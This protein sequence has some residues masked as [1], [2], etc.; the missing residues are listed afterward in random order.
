MKLSDYCCLTAMMSVMACTMGPVVHAQDG[1]ARYGHYL[2]PREIN[3]VLKT[4]NQKYPGTTRLINLATTP[5]GTPLLLIEIS[6]EAGKPKTT[7]AILVAANMEGT[8]PLSSMGALVLANLVLEKKEAYD[9]LAWYIIPCGNPDA[10]F[11]Y[12][13]KPLCMDPRNGTPFNE[14]LDD[15]TDEDGFNDL[16]GNGIITQMRVKD[17]QGEWMITE[18]DPQMMKRA[19]PFKGEKGVYKLYTEG[20]DDDRDGQ[21]N[22]DPP[23]GT[24]VGINFPHLFKHENETGGLW[25]GS[26]PE[27]FGIMKYV[28]E[29]PEIAMAF[30]F[31]STDFCRVSPRGGRRGSVNLNEI[32]IPERFARVFNADPEKTYTMAE[33]MDLIKPMMPEG[34]EVTESM[35]AGFLGLGAVINPLEEDLKF[36]NELSEKYKEYL[37]SKNFDAK[38]L[39]AEPDKDGSI[40]LWAYYHLGIPSFSMN[41]FTLPEP[42]EE[43]KESSGITVEILEKMSTEEFIAL[44]PGKVT[45]FMKEVG[46]PPQ[47]KAEQVIEMVKSGQ[48]PLAQIASM[49]KQMPK[50]PAAGKDVDPKTK[51]LRV[52]SNQ[53]LGGKGF[54]EWKP[55][56]HPTLGDV[57]IG[58]AV[59][60]TDNTPPPSM[61]DSL[62]NI[63][64]PYVLMLADK[65]PRLSI[66]T[67]RVTSRG[68]GVFELEAWVENKGYL[69]FPTAM[70]DRNKQ[71]APAVVEIDVTG[72]TLLSG[73]KRTTLNRIQGNGAEKIGWLLQAEKPVDITIRLMSKSAGNDQKTV[74]TGG[75]K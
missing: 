63:Q 69:P 50:A 43:K 37:K 21:Y 25:P 17:P 26:A 64:V 9:D 47:F 19:D 1:S 55:T 16:D 57:E 5:G 33:I 45:L 56:K 66:L 53:H 59:P 68:A 4:L 35:I 12:F 28:Y 15:L 72:A 32:K 11:R 10:A 61:I 67:T 40:E 65:L 20:I 34:M 44:D 60:F 24:N 52:F 7:P 49:I 13:S 46:A 42:L 2:N 48:M 18:G 54:V 8:V 29:H 39:D 38:R 51:A 75:V 23:G 58:G 30:T 71:P 41:L 14:D 31:G 6:N 27:A 36:Y 74:K 70:G 62:L 3:E 73:R 22:E